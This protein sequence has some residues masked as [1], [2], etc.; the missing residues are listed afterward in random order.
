MNINLVNLGRIEYVK[1]TDTIP[2]EET[3]RESRS[4]FTKHFDWIFR[5]LF[6]YRSG[7]CTILRG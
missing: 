7:V 3:M 5:D 2:L 4:G 1:T 6:L